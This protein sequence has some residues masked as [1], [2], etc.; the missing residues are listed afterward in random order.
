MTGLFVIGAHDVTIV[1]QYC[2][3]GFKNEESISQFWAINIIDGATNWLS[4]GAIV[5]GAIGVAISVRVLCRLGMTPTW[6]WVSWAAVVALLLSIVLHGIS[7][8]PAGDVVA[9]VATG[10]LLP[11]WALILAMRS[12]RF[13]PVPA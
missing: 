5:F 8:S 6:R 3:C 10:I 13:Q 2:D 7:D 1:Q 9:A 11:V 4:Y 12:D